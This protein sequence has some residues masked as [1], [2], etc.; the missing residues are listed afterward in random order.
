M[1]CWCCCCGW[2]TAYTA[3]LSYVCLVAF[4]FAHLHLFPPACNPVCLPAC[5][6][7]WH[8]VQCQLNEG[9]RV[10]DFDVGIER[11]SG[12]GAPGGDGGD[13]V[14]EHAVDDDNDYDGDGDDD[15]DDDAEF[16]DAADDDHDDARVMMMP[17]DDDDE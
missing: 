13:G 1:I 6:L 16:D 17:G 2:Q 5:L 4:L 12:T 14:V 10:G 7:V 11:K 3:I 8:L 15:G 9:H